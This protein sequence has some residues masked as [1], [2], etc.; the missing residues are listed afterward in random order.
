MYGLWGHLKH[1]NFN[2]STFSATNKLHDLGLNLAKP[3][4]L[5]LQSEDNNIYPICLLED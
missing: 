1:N 4:F 3:K 5:F 2:W